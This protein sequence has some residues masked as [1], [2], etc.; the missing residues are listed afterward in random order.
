[1][2]ERRIT[3]LMDRGGN[4][5]RFVDEN[6]Y[7]P[8]DREAPVMTRPIEEARLLD[9]DQEPSDSERMSERFYF[10]GFPDQEGYYMEGI[11]T[12]K[13]LPS[14]MLRDML[15]E[16]GVIEFMT[17]DSEVFLRKG[18]DYK[19]ESFEGKKFDRTMETRYR[20]WVKPPADF[21]PDH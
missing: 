16:R 9:R 7:G 11:L 2:A 14:K 13:Q 19:L 1:M 3:A 18:A 12:S 21:T 17:M 8:E 6:G 20:V 4:L 10:Q 5:A 15:Y